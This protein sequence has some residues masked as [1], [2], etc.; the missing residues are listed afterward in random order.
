MTVTTAPIPERVELPSPSWGE[1]PEHA[2]E[3]LDFTLRLMGGASASTDVSDAL[4]VSRQTVDHHRR[5]RTRPS[6]DTLRRYAD[7]LGIPVEVFFLTRD[8][9]IRWLVDNKSRDF[10]WTFDHGV[11]A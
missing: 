5:G 1:E 3:V 8:D 11:S 6:A 7:A 9:A 10:A 2:C 4:G